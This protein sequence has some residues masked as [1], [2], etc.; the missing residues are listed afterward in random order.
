MGAIKT[1]RTEK[2]LLRKGF[3]Q[4]DIYHHYFEFYHDGVMISRTYS[5]HSSS[6]ITDHVITQMAKQCGMERQFFLEFIAGPKSKEDYL[7]TLE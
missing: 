4:P 1:K 7:A 3:V 2:T 5:N 6:N